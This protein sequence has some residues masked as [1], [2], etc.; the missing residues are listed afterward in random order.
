[1]HD[2]SPQRETCACSCSRNGPSPTIRP[3]TFSPCDFKHL[4]TSIKSNHAFSGGELAHHSDDCRLS[5]RV[6]TNH[7]FFTHLEA[8]NV[9]AVSDQLKASRV[10]P[11]VV[12]EV[13][14]PRITHSHNPP[15]HS[16]R[17]L[18]IH[19]RI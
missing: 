13:L 10:Q 8:R 1:M 14:I 6:A 15:R 4:M 18:T 12:A 19:K 3:R 17:R 7:I 11:N 16:Q 5:I 9:N 2:T